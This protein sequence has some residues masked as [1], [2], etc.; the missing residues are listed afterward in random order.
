MEEEKQTKII[1]QINPTNTYTMKEQRDTPGDAPRPASS[2]RCSPFRSN[3]TIMMN[4]KNGK[5]QQKPTILPLYYHK[6]AQP[7]LSEER[8]GYLYASDK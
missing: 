1:K 4:K 3:T 6:F 2:G 5:Q 8:L 7:F